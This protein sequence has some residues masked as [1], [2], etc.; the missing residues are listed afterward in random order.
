MRGPG[1]ESLQA[2]VCVQHRPFQTSA[3]G[4]CCYQITSNHDM[5]LRA[6]P[7]RKS[8]GHI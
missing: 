2:V 6:A 1:V 3:D 7:F 4:H 5:L 8:F